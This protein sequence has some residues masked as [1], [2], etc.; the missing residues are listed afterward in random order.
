MP[1]FLS[2]WVGADACRRAGGHTKGRG[3]RSCSPPT[4]RASAPFVGVAPLLS[5]PGDERVEAAGAEAAAFFLGGGGVGACSGVWPPS[6][7][8]CHFAPVPVRPAQPLSPPLPSSRAPEGVRRVGGCAPQLHLAPGVGVQ[9]FSVPG[10]GG[11]GWAGAATVPPRPYSAPPHSKPQKAGKPAGAHSESTALASRSTP[12]AEMSGAMKNWANLRWGWGGGGEEGAG[13]GG[14]RPLAT[15][16]PEKKVQPSSSAGWKA[17]TR[18]SSA[19][20]RCAAFT[21]K[22]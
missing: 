14:G 7:L 16:A 17:G 4:P 20:S 21:S 13:A 8:R 12:S 11:G 1:L 5:R 10:R 2:L 3:G 15:Q 9:V 19:C 18:L 22:W 6:Q